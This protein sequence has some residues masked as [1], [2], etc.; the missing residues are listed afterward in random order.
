MCKVQAK[1][2]FYIVQSIGFTA[3]H[4]KTALTFAIYGVKNV[5]WN[6]KSNAQG[7]DIP[8][9]KSLGCTFRHSF[10]SIGIYCQ[11]IEICRHVNLMIQ[12]KIWCSVQS[13]PH[14]HE[15]WNSSFYKISGNNRS[16]LLFLSFFLKR[17][18][19]GM[20]AH[21]MQRTTPFSN[22]GCRNPVLSEPSTHFWAWF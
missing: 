11:Y 2:L 19:A 22:S 1:Y 14:S 8:G 5:S 16:F 6:L 21:C 3:L 4:H 10:T 13:L 18:I 9:K 12:K 20:C 7:Q 17:V 15:N